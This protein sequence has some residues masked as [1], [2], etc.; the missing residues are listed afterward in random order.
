MLLYR[1]LL[2]LNLG[3]VDV[4]ENWSAYSGTGAS[5]RGDRMQEGSSRREQRTAACHS[6]VDNLYCLR[7]ST[8]VSNMYVSLESCPLPKLASRTPGRSE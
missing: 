6:L 7:E 5:F 4:G 2:Y 1:L 8:M 3:R